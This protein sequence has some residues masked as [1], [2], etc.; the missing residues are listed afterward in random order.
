[1]VKRA[2]IAG[3]PVLVLTVDQVGG[4]NREML[5]RFEKQDKRQCSGCHDRS[6]LEKSVQRKPMFDGLNL[7][8][9]SRPRMLWNHR[10]DGKKNTR[11]L[12]LEL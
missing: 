8:E 6:S 5:K 7:W 11:I 3:C 12:L 2:E 4:T 10:A 1:M 9:R